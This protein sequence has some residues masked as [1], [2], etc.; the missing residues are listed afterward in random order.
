[1][2][3]QILNFGILFI[4]LVLVQ[5]LV[6]NNISIFNVATP[7]IFIY[8]IARLP[9]NTN[10]NLMMTIS[11]F[12][13]LIVDIFSNTQ[14]MNALACTLLGTIRNPIIALYVTRKEEITD[15]IPSIRS[16]GIGVY[17]K[18]L[19]SIVL[20]YCCIITAIELFSVRNI[21]SALLRIVGSTAISFI[22]L[23]GIDSIVNTRNEKRL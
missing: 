1:M 16:L 18:Y 6:C 2:A 21:L 15:P 19:V 10:I 11:F 9:I 13:G 17:M 5:V 4:I 12:T 8:I 20:F 7:F 3:K 14:G 23:L 22:I